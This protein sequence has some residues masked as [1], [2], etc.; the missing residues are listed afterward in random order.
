MSFLYKEW[1]FI[2]VLS[3]CMF[4]VSYLWSD[5]IINWFRDKSLGKREEVIRLLDLMFVQINHRQITLL[6]IFGSFGLGF[7]F[8]LLLWPNVIAGILIGMVITVL[9]WSA[10]LLVVNSMYERRCNL[11]VDQ[12]VDGL[13]IMANGI[14]SGLSV[15]QSMERVVEN[16]KNPISQEFALVLSQVKLGRTLEESLVELGDRIDRPDVM[17]FV[18]AINILKETGG[19]LAETFQTIVL[20]VRERQKVERKIQALTAQGMMQGTIIS[21]APLALLGVFSA[22]D[23]AFVKPLFTTTLGVILLTIMLVLIVVGSVVMRKL[24]KIKV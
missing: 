9:G 17:M 6:M 11:F 1:F 22:V 20:V 16:L 15:T 18:T 14:K 19:N 21:L 7:V 8:F 10:P 3:I 4:V 5:K 12:M 24:V 2:P 23:P 13:T